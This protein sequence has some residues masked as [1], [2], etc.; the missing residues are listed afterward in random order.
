MKIRLL[1]EA[2]EDNGEL[3]GKESIVPNGWETS[4]EGKIMIIKPESLSPQYRTRENQYFLA[5]GG[6]GCDPTKIGS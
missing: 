2:V 3:L 4:C 6:F 1:K 5:L